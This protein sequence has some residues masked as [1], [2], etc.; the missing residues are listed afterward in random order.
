MLKPLHPITVEYAMKMISDE[1]YLEEVGDK[2]IK[3]SMQFVV[4]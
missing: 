1:Y 3:I 2:M 4:R